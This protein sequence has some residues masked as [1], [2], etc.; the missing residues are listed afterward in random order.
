MGDTVTIGEKLGKL[1]EY[2][3]EFVEWSNISYEEFI[4]NTK[5]KRSL[6][7]QMEII[8]DTAIS[9]NNMILKIERGETSAE[10]FNSFINLAE[11]GVIEMDFALNIAPST[12]LRNILVHEYQEID[13]KKVYDSFKDVKKY[14][15][16]YM[17]FIQKYLK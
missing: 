15:K 11:A 9:I 8:I 16:E 5:D 4:R 12:G 6:E 7:K 1:K 10:Y 3:E 14:Y 2:Y 13:D 17:Q